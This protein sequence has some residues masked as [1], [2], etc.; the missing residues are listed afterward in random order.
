MGAGQVL[1]LHGVVAV[2]FAEHAA[3]AG[4]QLTG[5]QQPGGG[6]APGQ[7]LQPAV[8]EIELGGGQHGAGGG[9][10]PFGHG[11]QHVFGQQ[12]VGVQDK[13]HLAVQPVQHGVVPFAEADILRQGQ[14]GHPRVAKVG[15][16]QLAAAAVGAAVVHHI[17]GQ[18][19]GGGVLQDAAHRGA[20]LLIVTV[21]HDA[22]ADLGHGA[23]LTFSGL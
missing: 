14:H 18:R 10:Q 23:L 4:R 15:P 2:G 19:G 11:F 7:R 13:V 22:G 9:Q 17:Q 1:V 16:G 12:D 6:L 20:D 3:E 5:Q 21:R 8:R